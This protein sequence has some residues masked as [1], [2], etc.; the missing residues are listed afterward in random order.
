MSFTSHRH[1]GFVQ[2]TSLFTVSGWLLRLYPQSG[3]SLF[4]VHVTQR[5]QIGA[6]VQNSEN[7][8][9]GTCCEEEE[10]MT[11]LSR[12]RQHWTRRQKRSKLGRVAPCCNNSSV[13][14]AHAKQCITHQALEWDLAPFFRIA[15]R[16]ASS[17]DGARA[18]VKS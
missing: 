7:A 13:H 18:T 17:V 15:S 11:I 12:P 8:K 3:G 14:I 1:L 4:C 6:Q 10:A 16:V 2:K 9:V 5:D